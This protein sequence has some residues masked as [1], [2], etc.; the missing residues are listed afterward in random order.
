MQFA[1]FKSDEEDRLYIDR[2]EYENWKLIKWHKRSK[3]KENIFIFF[4][5]FISWEANGNHNN[6]INKLV[7]SSL[8]YGSA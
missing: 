8:A 6:N 1:I 3:M 7:L 5:N 4:V 2:I